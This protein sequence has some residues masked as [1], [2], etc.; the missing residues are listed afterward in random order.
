MDEL[1]KQKIAWTCP[2]LEWY[3]FPRKKMENFPK[4]Y[5]GYFLSESKGR[6]LKWFLS[7][8][9]IRRPIRHKKQFFAKWRP[10]FEEYNKFIWMTM[11]KYVYLLQKIDYETKTWRHMWAYTE[12]WNKVRA[13]HNAFSIQ[14]LTASSDI[15]LAIDVLSWWS[16]ILLSN[17]SLNNMLISYVRDLYSPRIDPF[18]EK[19]FDK[20]K[21]PYKYMDLACLF[22]VQILPERYDL[23]KH[24]EDNKM[25]FNQFWDFVL[26]YVSNW[27]E[28]YW[29]CYK[30]TKDETTSLLWQIKRLWKSKK[31]DKLLEIRRFRS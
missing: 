30:L 7:R 29:R 4:T 8:I 6:R 9:Y 31:H 24:G 28:K 2:K 1:S 17:P 19:N 23:L 13:R 26:N 3:V 11:V 16:T 18:D 25:T 14:W 27:N 15:R 22:L 10:I 21:Y 20:L 5:E 12:N